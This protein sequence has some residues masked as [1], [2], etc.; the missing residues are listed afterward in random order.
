MQNIKTKILVMMFLVTVLN[1]PMAFAQPSALPKYSGVDDTIKEYICT[2]SESPNPN[3]LAN[4]INKIYRFGIAIGAVALVFFAVVAGYSYILGGEKGK[5]KG[6]TVFKNALV[7][8][9]I[10]LTSYVFLGFINPDLVAFKPIN[11]PQF[12]DPKLPK[13]EDIG[14]S[15]DCVITVPG[16]GEQTLPGGGGGKGEKVP[17]SSKNLVNPRDLGL[18][19]SSGQN[20]K[21]ICKEFGEK[22]LVAYNSMKPTSWVVHRTVG[23]GAESQCHKSNNEFTGT[24]ADI[25]FTSSNDV[26]NADSW[27]KLCRALKS[28]GVYPHNE[29]GH[30]GDGTEHLRGKLGDCGSFHSEKQ[31]TGDHIH[32]MWRTGTDN[33]GGGATPPVS[34]GSRPYCIA[35]TQFNFLCN[36]PAGPPTGDDRVK[37]G[38]FTSSNP[39][40]QKNLTEVKNRLAKA[41]ITPSQVRQVYRPHE[42][43]AHLRSYWEASALIQGKTDEWVRSTGYYC[44]GSIQYVKKS[45]ID[46]LSK[47][48]KDSILAHARIHDMHKLDEPTT[49]LSDHGFGYA[50]DYGSATPSEVTKLEKVGLCHNLGGGKWNQRR[51]GGHYVLTE[52]NRNDQGCK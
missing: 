36:S 6:K 8:M 5:E 52:K 41:G 50:V 3:E 15:D 7:G 26:K 14:F 17:C 21:L 20:N 24:C 12:L 22:L 27:N 11:P 47:P 40:I 1:P 49:C 37:A 46:K 35:G 2:P 4:C 48:Q 18:P 33:G 45:D 51:D 38:G 32:A 42:Y 39:E 13:C 9:I 43:S 25:D 19:V 34:G 44:D 31:A 10:L 30:T 16:G 28:A 29:V 23:G